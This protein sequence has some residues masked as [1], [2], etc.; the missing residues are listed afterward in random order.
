MKLEITDF[1]PEHITRV[2]EIERECFSDP[3]SEQA[4]G[5]D[6]SNPLAKYFVCARD[7]SVVGYVGA[8]CVLDE[9]YITNIAVDKNCRKLG[10][11]H[12]LMQAIID[13]A[14]QMRASFITLEVRQ[15]NISAIS[16]YKSMRF[17]NQGI[18]RGFYRLPDEDAI[19]M[20]R[21]GN[22][23]TDEYSSN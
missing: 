2:A 15:S 8:H 21:F 13:H 6:L 11:G 22:E 17:C 14:Q 16:L 19:I 5:D 10:I 18:R 9:C 1:L 12:A 4:I 7:A 3:W 23:N 20:T